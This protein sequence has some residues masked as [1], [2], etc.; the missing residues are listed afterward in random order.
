MHVVVHERGDDGGLLTGG[1]LPLPYE[2]RLAH[3]AVAAHMEQ[4]REIDLLRITG[5]GLPEGRQLCVTPDEP[6]A[7]ASPIDFLP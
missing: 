6:R 2:G 1:G 3:A 7:P 4:K 5:E